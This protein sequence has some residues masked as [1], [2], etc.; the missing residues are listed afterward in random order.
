MDKTIIKAFTFVK[1]H[2][3]LLWKEKRGSL[4]YYF[5]AFSTRLLLHQYLFNLLFFAQ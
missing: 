1:F 4:Q 5:Q 2:L 3:M